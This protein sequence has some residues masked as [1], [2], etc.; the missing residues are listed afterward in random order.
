MS[1]KTAS[2][3]LRGAFLIAP[4][5]V[6]SHLP[7]LHGLITGQKVDFGISERDEELKL[8]GLP[9]M[10]SYR[11]DQQQ[12]AA[13]SI[14]MYTDFERIPQGSVAIVNLFGPVLKYG[15]MCSY[16]MV[17]KA[18][19][20]H[21]IAASGKFTSVILDVDSPGGQADGTQLLAD[22]IKHLSLPVI[23]VVNDGM[24]ASAAMWIGSAC[25]A[26]YATKQTDTFG[27]IGVFCTLADMKGYFEAQGLK[28]HEIYSDASS[29]KNKSY[30]DAMNGDY[31]LKK[32]ELNYLQQAFADAVAE[33]RGSRLDTSKENPFTGKMYTAQLATDIGLIDGVKS[34]EEVILSAIDM[35]ADS[36]T[37]I[38]NENTMF[39]QRFKKLSSLKGMNKAQITQEHV[40]AANEEIVAEGIDGVTLALDTELEQHE[41]SANRITELESQLSAR[42]A[43][44][45]AHVATIAGLNAKLDKKPA[46]DAST[47]PASA[48]AETISN[49]NAGTANEFETSYDRDLKKMFGK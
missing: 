15:D 10:R 41:T 14:G 33:N 49:T 2:A 48:D 45:S 21:R 17:D 11:L 16:G 47:P 37:N 5:Y 3:I 38:N 19:L 44:I 36:T 27:S 9:V 39:G 13:Y 30:R 46:T 34:Y 26:I 40:T 4:V 1:F 6:Q 31:T 28:I 23:A 18:G 29:D 7:L 35:G 43:T 20:L 22:T 12:L 8:E 24:M 25:K 42:D 32:A